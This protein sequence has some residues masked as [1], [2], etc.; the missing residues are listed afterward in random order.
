MHVV[1]FV[2]TILSDSVENTKRNILEIYNIFKLP[3]WWICHLI[4]TKTFSFCD[5]NVLNVNHPCH[6]V[7]P[8][9]SFVL[10]IL[11]HEIFENTT[12]TTK[13]RFFLLRFCYIIGSE[14]CS[15]RGLLCCY[16]RCLQ[17]LHGCGDA[18]QYLT[19]PQFRNSC[20]DPSQLLRCFS[21][22]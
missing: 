9:A 19:E 4:P 8:H 18:S 12:N 2:G 1:H 22:P 10:H 21:P 13:R 5:L 15:Q 16:Q 11:R 7:K 14:S 17:V 6:V 20:F 3:T